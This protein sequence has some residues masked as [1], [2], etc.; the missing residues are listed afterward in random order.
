MLRSQGS[1]LYLSYQQE[2]DTLSMFL[3]DDIVGNKS[4][5]SAGVKLYFGYRLT[6][7]WAFQSDSRDLIKRACKDS[8]WNDDYGFIN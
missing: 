8:R 1:T 4:W 7:R 5:V 6:H 2:R 3:S